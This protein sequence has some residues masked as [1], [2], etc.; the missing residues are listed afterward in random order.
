MAS[1]RAWTSTGIPRCPLAVCPMAMGVTPPALA[2]PPW[3]V[4]AGPRAQGGDGSRARLGWAAVRE[5]DVGAWHGNPLR[6]PAVGSWH[7]NV[8]AGTWYKHVVREGGV[9]TRYRGTAWEWRCGS[10][11]R[12]HRVGAWGGIVGWERGAGVRYR[13]VVRQRGTGNAVRECGVGARCGNTGPLVLPSPGGAAGRGCFG[14]GACDFLPSAP[15]QV[16]LQTHHG[17]LTCPPPALGGCRG[18]MSPGPAWET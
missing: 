6:E 12:G 18:G 15:D 13:P 8:V 1:L 3:L 14:V 16:A 10:T 2:P 5:C 4:A 9:G 17:S 7:R 11:L